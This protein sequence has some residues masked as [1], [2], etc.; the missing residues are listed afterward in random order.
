VAAINNVETGNE[1]TTAAILSCPPTENLTVQVNNAAVFYQLSIV[2]AGRQAKAAFSLPGD[3]LVG[4]AHIW[5][6]ERLLQPGF[7]NFSGSDTYGGQ[8]IGIRFRSFLKGKPAR[9]SA[10]N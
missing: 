9:V 3:S 7:W 8:I 6:D 2:N 4:G 5:T 10:S 1:Y